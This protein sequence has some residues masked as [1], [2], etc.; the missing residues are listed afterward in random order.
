MKKIFLEELTAMYELGDVRKL[1]K[2]VGLTQHE[3]AVRAGVSQSLLAKIETGKISPGYE[4][5]KKIFAVIDQITKKK[6]VKASEV[7]T[8]KVI[9]ISMTETVSVAIKKMGLHKIS[10]MPVIDRGKSVGLLTES[11]IIEKMNKGFSA[12]SHVADIMDGAP[13]TVSEDVGME[14]VIGLLKHFP[15]VLVT[16]KGDIT[17]VITKS[18][19]LAKVG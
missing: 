14:V 13:P 5:V 19:V 15:I 18:D 1:R 11:C 9:S 10:Q 2:K 8:R 6:E 17:G 16:D 3:L 7:A 12:G 4:R